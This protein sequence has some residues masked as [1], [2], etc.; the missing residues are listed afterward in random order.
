LSEQA[1]RTEQAAR[2][3]QADQTGEPIVENRNSDPIL[4]RVKYLKKLEASL[5]A[6]LG[7]PEVESPS[8]QDVSL[9]TTAVTLLDKVQ[10]S[11]KQH[12]QRS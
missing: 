6:F 2:I 9:N 4:E 12:R 5:E 7:L 1:A 11:L 10:T 8:R 3:E